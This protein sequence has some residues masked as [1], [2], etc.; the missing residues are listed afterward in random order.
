MP[1]ASPISIVACDVAAAP[2]ADVW[3]VLSDRSSMSDRLD[4]VGRATMLARAICTI[5]LLA[6]AVSPAAQAAQDR[7]APAG[8]AGAEASRAEGHSAWA[9]APHPLTA[10]ARAVTAVEQGKPKRRG[11]KVRRAWPANPRAPRPRNRLA[12]WLARQVG[13]VR[14]R[15]A[16]TAAQGNDKLL[17]RSFDIPES[18][19]AYDRLVDRSYT[20]DN[21]L[22]TFAFISV[23]ARGLAEQLLDQLKALQR[24]DGSLEYAFNVDTGASVRDF[25]AGAM[26]WVGYAAVAYRK[27]YE[28]RRYDRM[29]AGI[30]R[31]LLALR[32]RDGLIRGGPDVT[33]VSTQ[34]NLLA[35]GM[36]RDLAADLGRRGTL[37]T[38]LEYEDID[39]A[40]DSIGDATLAHLLV[41]EGPLA[42]FRQGVE[43]PVVPADVQALGALYLDARGDRR[44]EQVA[45]FLRQNFYVPPRAG[46]AGMLS[47]YRPFLGAGAPDVIWSEG[48]LEAAT[49][50]HRVGLNTAAADDA[51]AR[52]RSTIRGRSVGPAGADRDV[53]DRVWGEFHTW[54]TSAAGSWLLIRAARAELLFDR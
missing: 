20:Y 17:V 33:W 8:G 12:R 48:T 6:A 27:V 45:E 26:A 37:A 41:Q 3:G 29:L 23:R 10:T 13:A 30:V 46:P 54:P 35:A 32:N 49:A 34:H 40:A 2:V 21:A 43:D 16:R 42:Y 28:N 19:P 7:S 24:T 51:V 9:P 18:D 22:A 14:E 47:G 50:F 52:L 53:V 25:R 15:S 38:G 44:A 39:D 1:A 4:S 11:G 36:L 31:Y 5:S